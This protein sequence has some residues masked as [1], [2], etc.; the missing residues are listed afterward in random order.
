MTRPLYAT[1]LLPLLL[2][3]PALAQGRS[4]TLDSIVT[5]GQL[6]CGVGGDIAGFSLL[7]NQGVMRGLD[8]DGC[9]AIA[10]A[11]LG[12]AKKV[13]FVPLTAVTRFTALQSGEI[14]VLLRNTSWTLTRESNLGLM[15][16]ATN[17]WDSTGFIVRKASG[18]KSASELNNATICVRPG[19]STEIDLTD[20]TRNHDLKVTPVLIGDVNAI[21][22]AFLSGRCDAYTSDS[23][24][25]AGFRYSQGANADQLLILPET[26]SPAQSGSMVRKGD[27]TW[28]DIVRWVHFAQV[29][30]E[31]MA[32]T[33]ISVQG[34]LTSTNP[35][36]KRLLGVD[37]GLG[38]SLGL[39]DRW[40]Y[41]VIAQVGNYGEMYER[42]IAPLGLPRGRNALVSEGG[43][44]A[45]PLLR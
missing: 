17:F 28:F 16:A 19:T 18:I 34:Q 23:S 41:N 15:F 24:Q 37:G 38:K 35:D 22:Q 14:D 7:D 27:G 33:S 45:A 36:I 8:A 21:Q 3:T 10:A 6:V 31:S 4:P 30:G 1:L 13:R 40:G 42:D 39:D 2:A 32:V 5:R 20:W 43:Q 12:D 25:L 9:R 44:Q 11:V 26:V 29:A